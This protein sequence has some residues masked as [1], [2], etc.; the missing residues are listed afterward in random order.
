[1]SSPRGK[2]GE[3]SDYPFHL[4]QQK[5]REPNEAEERARAVHLRSVDSFL[6]QLSSHSDATSS[7]VQSPMSPSRF[8]SVSFSYPVHTHAALKL[9]NVQAEAERHAFRAGLRAEGMD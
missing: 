2:G 9:T 4:S 8:L 7:L 1:M 5:E 6:S 3:G